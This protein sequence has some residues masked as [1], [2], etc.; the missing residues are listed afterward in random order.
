[1]DESQLFRRPGSP[2]WVAG[3]PARRGA[4]PVQSAQCAFVLHIRWSALPTIE[5]SATIW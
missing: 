2:R 1:M 5:L 3:A 4:D